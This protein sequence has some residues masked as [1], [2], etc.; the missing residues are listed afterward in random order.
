MSQIGSIATPLSRNQI[1]EFAGSFRK[2]FGLDKSP[3][4]DVGKLIEFVLPQFVDGYLF[5]VKT[6]KE[7]GS[8]HGLTSPDERKIILREDVYEGL[9]DGKGRDR[10]T[11]THELGHLV[12]HPKGRVMLSRS[13]VKPARFCDPEWQADC[14]AGEFLMPFNLVKGFKSPAQIAAECGVSDM[15]AK[16]QWRVMHP[17]G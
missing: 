3:Y 2:L 7:M 15:A 14:F 9:C 4:A 12:L 11:A 10:F 6:T 1:R 16:V 8:N 5:D 17:N 13:E